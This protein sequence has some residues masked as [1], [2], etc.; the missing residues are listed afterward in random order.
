MGQA[1]ERKKND[2]YYGKPVH[3]GLVISSP[4]RVNG[5]DYLHMMSTGLH[6][7]E[8][9]FALMFWDKLVWPDGAISF[10][11]GPDELFLEDCGIIERPRYSIDGAS[12]S[13]FLAGQIMAY[14]DMEA[15][16]PGAWALA[17]G[18]NSLFV[19]GPR[20]V[21]G[22]GAQIE[23][24]RAVPI[25]TVDTPLQEILEFK[26]RRKDELLSFR[27]HIESLA[28]KVSASDEPSAELEKQVS[29]VEKACSDLVA[30][31]KDFQFPMHVSTFKTS[32]NLKPSL[33]G[34][35]VGAWQGGAT[36]GLEI[37]TLAAGFAGLRSAVRI[38]TDL[39]LRS[40][41]APVSP[42]KYAYRI[43]DELI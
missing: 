29:E 5:A 41:K 8:L 32:L 35:V 20:L 13:G 28:E 12:G 22:K 42:Y 37:A 16:E 21:V 33:V 30:V 6:P 18:E 9:R 10:E 14:Q 23:L 19:E 7:Q 36:Y 3:R 17:Q 26:Q 31:G 1:K 2:P 24:T 15:R 25:P 11:G 4:A 39:G 38:E 40:I 43:S 34:E 27:L